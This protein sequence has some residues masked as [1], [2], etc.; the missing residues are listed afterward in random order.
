MQDKAPAPEIRISVIVY[1]QLQNLLLLKQTVLL[2]S[3][4]V[5]QAVSISPIHLVSLSVVQ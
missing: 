1:V 5:Q 3:A 2:S 4:A